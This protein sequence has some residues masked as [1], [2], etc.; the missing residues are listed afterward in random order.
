MFCWQSFKSD[1][2]IL[3]EE[4]MGLPYMKDVEVS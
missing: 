2:I 3:G 4:N 1:Q